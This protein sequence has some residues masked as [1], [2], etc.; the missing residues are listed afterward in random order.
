[1]NWYQ[2]SDEALLNLPTHRLLNI[3]RQMQGSAG[4]ATAK[5][6]AGGD[7]DEEAENLRAAVKAELDS[8]PHVERTS[9]KQNHSDPFQSRNRP[10]PYNRYRDE[11]GFWAWGVKPQETPTGPITNPEDA[12]GKQ[13]FKLSGKPFKSKAKYNTVKEVTVNPHT[14]LP[15]FTFEEDS[16]IVDAHICD[17]RRNK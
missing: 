7:V 1:M 13:V 6:N 3:Y 10:N 5:I 12:I 17:V 14:K 9:K 8:R 16:S 11:D 4:Y 15:A 2:L